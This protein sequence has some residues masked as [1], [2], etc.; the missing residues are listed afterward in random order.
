MPTDD[1]SRLEIAKDQYAVMLSWENQADLI[2]R[3]IDLTSDT[4]LLTSLKGAE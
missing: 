2:K 4:D 1:N 3:I